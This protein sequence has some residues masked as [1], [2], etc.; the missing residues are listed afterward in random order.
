MNTKSVILNAS[1]LDE[2]NIQNIFVILPFLQK[3]FIVKQL[4][5]RHVD[6]YS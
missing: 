1:Y 3:Y 4:V 5:S 6:L 2:I